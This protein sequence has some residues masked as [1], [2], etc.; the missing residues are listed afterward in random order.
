MALMG[1]FGK[2]KPPVLGVD[3]SAAAV[4]VLELSRFGPG[5]RVESYGVAPLARN[6]VVD[7]AIAE[8]ESVASVVRAVVK[9]SRT[10]LRQ[11]AVAVPGSLAI[12][13]RVTLPA[14]LDDEELEAQVLVEAQRHIP[15]ALEEVSLDFEVLGPS[16]KHPKFVEVLLVA[17]RRENVEDRIAVLETAGLTVSVVDVEP[18]VIEHALDLVAPAL[19]PGSA[20]RTIAVADIGALVTTINVFHRRELIYTREQSFGGMQLTEEI[21]RRYGL[22]YQEAGLAKK[23]GS[24]PENYPQ[25]VLEPFRRA[26]VEQIRRAFQYY[27]SST[28]QRGV[29]AIV[30]AG[31][32]AAIPDLAHYVEAEM[33]V[34]TVVAD[35][36]ANLTLAGRVNPDG[37][38]QDAPA[39]LVACGLALRSFD[40]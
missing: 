31:G 13:K 39:L 24:L 20:D 1:W 23:Q 3:I 17:T 40:P 36:F 14:G 29:D 28:A 27:L 21:Q 19:P 25:Q 8:V 34:P 4:K 9:Q 22:S 38:R 11:A 6:S 10:Q 5:Y 15:Y 32:C 18:F 26:L 30:L 2:R 35:P 16:P 12:T 37:L 7:N 33:E